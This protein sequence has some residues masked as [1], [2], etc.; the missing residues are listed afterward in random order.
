MRLHFV[1]LAGHLRVQYL[2]Q[3]GYVSVPLTIKPQ[4]RSGVLPN[5]PHHHIETERLAPG[6]YRTDARGRF[7]NLSPPLQVR[8]GNATTRNTVVVV[9]NWSQSPNVRRIVS[10][11]CSPELDSFIKRVLVWNKS[12]KPLA[13]LV[14]DITA[15]LP[16][17]KVFQCRSKDFYPDHLFGRKVRDHQLD[18]EHVL[19][20]TV[21]RML[22]VGCRVLLCSSNDLMTFQTHLI[23]LI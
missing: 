2:P 22:A 8:E 10:L 21:L 15:L 4:L 13:Y 6:S 5:I 7:V 9:L 18:G 3:V 17:F 1:H 20:C 16:S 19:S 14:S 23:L 11:L 12:P